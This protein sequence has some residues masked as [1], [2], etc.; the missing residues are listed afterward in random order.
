MKFSANLS[1]TYLQ[2]LVWTGLDA[3]HQ[4]RGREGD[5]LHISEVVGRVLVQDHLADG[6]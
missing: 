2:H 6:D 1:P 3:R 4:V 5:L